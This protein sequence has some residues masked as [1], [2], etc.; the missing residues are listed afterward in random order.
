MDDLSRLLADGFRPHGDILKRTR[1]PH[2]PR[3]SVVGIRPDGSLFCNGTPEGRA[4][5]H[6]HWERWESLASQLTRRLSA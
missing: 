4:E 1:D 5:A 2:G 6:E 3:R